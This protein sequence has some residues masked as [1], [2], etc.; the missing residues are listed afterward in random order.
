MTFD[1]SQFIDTLK[2]ERKT[3]VDEFLLLQQ[4]TFW[5]NIG[6]LKF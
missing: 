3:L 6:G 1:R 2:K 5:P 4:A